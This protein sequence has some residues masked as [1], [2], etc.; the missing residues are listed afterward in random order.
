LHEAE[1]RSLRATFQVAEIT[2]FNDVARS[3]A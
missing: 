1:L 2:A 3:Q